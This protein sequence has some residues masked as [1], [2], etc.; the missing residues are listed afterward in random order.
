MFEALL[1][2][3]ALVGV[4]GQHG[5]QPVGQLARRLGVPLVLLRQHVEQA[6]GLQLR[7]VTKLAWKEK[8]RG[9]KQ[10]VRRG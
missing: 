2:R 3:G 10:D 8:E 6:P 7:D 4:E 1:G 5:D 9:E